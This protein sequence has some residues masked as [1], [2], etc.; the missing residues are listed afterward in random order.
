MY[1]YAR[2]KTAD[3]PGDLSIT[4]FALG[5]AR[6]LGTH[7]MQELESAT[8]LKW[9]FNKSQVKGPGSFTLDFTLI[10]ATGER[11]TASAGVLLTM[12]AV[13]IDF[14][15]PYGGTAKFMEDPHDKPSAVAGIVAHRLKDSFTGE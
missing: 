10:P 6:A 11:L 2:T 15:M 4:E 9:W 12:N 8:G 3:H 1:D 14:V 7:L 13:H 5:Y